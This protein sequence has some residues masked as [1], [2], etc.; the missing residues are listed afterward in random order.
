MAERNIGAAFTVKG[1]NKVLSAFAKISTKVGTLANDFKRLTIIS[2]FMIAGIIKATLKFANMGINIENAE[3][4]FD[5]LIKK[6]QLETDTL[7]QLSKAAEGTIRDLDLMTKSNVILQ[8]ITGVTT[9][10]LVRL[11]QASK[12]LGEAI[13]VDATLALEKFAQ[14]ISSGRSQVLK[15]IGF[16]I[17]L[18]RVQ[19]EYAK[20]LGV[21]I[22]QLTQVQK[23]TALYLEILRQTDEKLELFKDIS[24]EAGDAMR[25]MVTQFKNLRDRMAVLLIQ[26]PAFAKSVERI[27]KVFNEWQTWIEKNP[28]KLEAFFRDLLT[29]LTGIV[30]A[31]LEFIPSMLNFFK[32]LVENAPILIRIFL[33]I[34]GALAGAAIGSAFGPLGGIIGLGA[35]ALGGGFLGQK[36]VGGFQS[37][38]DNTRVWG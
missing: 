37:Q 20:S 36:V 1:I 15:Y 18:I 12:K 28:Q 19:D 14:S 22:R 24:N 2:A 33:I 32:F 27:V 25:R 3:R 8:S 9:S 7:K 16:N 17:N 31:A 30:K 13:G 38:V 5:A 35:G 4:A 10:D 26:S 6:H 29:S 11:V 21:N 34:K 23:Q